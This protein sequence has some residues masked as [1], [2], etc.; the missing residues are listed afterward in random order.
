MGIIAAT[1]VFEHLSALDLPFFTTGIKIGEITPTSAVVWARLTRD[2]IRVAD[3]GKQPNFLFLD[4]TKNEWHD[5]AYFKST[6]KED[7]PDRKVQV[8]MPAST[9][10]EQ[11][12]G[13]VPGKK[14]FISIHY[15]IKGSG[16]GIKHPGRL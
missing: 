11:L 16:I 12:D 3:T 13:A 8:N 15:S 9:T 5:I 1:P 7:R 10:V 2:S 6:F 4:E 14:G